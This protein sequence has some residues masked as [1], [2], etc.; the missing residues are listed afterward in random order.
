MMM[1][2]MSPCW[3]IGRDPLGDLAVPGK[4]IWMII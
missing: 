3:S 1:M 4:R 2:M